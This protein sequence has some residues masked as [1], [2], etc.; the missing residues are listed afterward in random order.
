MLNKVEMECHESV[1]SET[2]AETERGDLDDAKT[3]MARTE[4][5]MLAYKSSIDMVVVSAP[6][7]NQQHG[8]YSNSF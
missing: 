7:H 3:I 6:R 8:I 5:L 2:Q 4:R 1:F